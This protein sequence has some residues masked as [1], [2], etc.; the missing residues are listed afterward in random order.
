[1]RAMRRHLA[2]HDLDHWAGSFFDALREQA[3]VQPTGRTAG[4]ES[5]S[6]SP[7]EG[8]AQG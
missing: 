7:G 2:K 8:G 4:R 3:S 5:A 1:M 6:L